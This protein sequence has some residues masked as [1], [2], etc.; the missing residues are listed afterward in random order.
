MGLNVLPITPEFI[1]IVILDVYM[2]YLE[3]ETSF[4][5]DE[6][7]AVRYYI[8]L[9]VEKVSVTEF[10]NEAAL[11]VLASKLIFL[12][13]IENEENALVALKVIKDICTNIS[14]VTEVVMQFLSFA[15]DLLNNFQTSLNCYFDT[16]HAHLSVSKIECSTLSFKVIREMSFQLTSMIRSLPMPNQESIAT[17]LIPLFIKTVRIRHAV[18]SDLVKFEDFLITQ[19]NLFKTI[20]VLIKSHTSSEEHK[21]SLFSALVSWIYFLPPNND[22]LRKEALVVSRQFI[23]HFRLGFKHYLTHFL[24]EGFLLGTKGHA[25]VSLGLKN[26]VLDLLGDIV[27]N[28]LLDLTFDQIYPIVH[29]L[30]V[31]IHD[32]SIK[33][34]SQVNCI[35]LLVHIV[36]F[37]AGHPQKE[38][39]NP[40]Y[41]AKIIEAFSEKKEHLHMLYEDILLKYQ[42]YQD[43]EVSF[44]DLHDERSSPHELVRETSMLT[45]MLS[46]GLSHIVYTTYVRLKATKLGES[47]YSIHHSPIFYHR[48]FQTWLQCLNLNSKILKLYDYSGDKEFEAR[49]S[50]LLELFVNTFSSLDIST[51]YQ[52]MATNVKEVYRLILENE[53]TFIKLPQLLLKTEHARIFADLWF[54]FLWNTLNDFRNFNDEE[55]R[56]ISLL[57]QYLFVD[58]NMSAETYIIFLKDNI[59]SFLQDI[60]SSNNDSNLSTCFKILLNL[61]RILPN[62]NI[63]CEELGIMLPYLCDRIDQ[64]LKSDLEDKRYG[65]IDFMINLP[66]SITTLEPYFDKFIDM[67]I[68]AME[69]LHP[70]YIS[71][72]LCGFQ[73]LEQW[74]NYISR[75]I[76]HLINDDLKARMMKCL[77][78]NIEDPPNKYTPYSIRIL[79]KISGSIWKSCDNIKLDL[80]KKIDH[81]YQVPVMIS[82]SKFISIPLKHCFESAWGILSQHKNYPVSTIRKIFNLIK[83]FAIMAL[84]Y[85]SNNYPLMIHQSNPQMALDTTSIEEF[86]GNQMV[87]PEE[88]YSDRQCTEILFKCLIYSQTID[89]VKEEATYLVNWAN[90]YFSLI[91]VACTDNSDSALKDVNLY[92]DAIGVILL[93]YENLGIDCLNSILTYLNIH[94]NLSSYFWLEHFV[95]KLRD[96]CFSNDKRQRY[97]GCHGF[98]YLATVLPR[99]LILKYQT[100]FYHGISN[101]IACTDNSNFTIIQ[102]GMQC[103][104]DIAVKIGKGESQLLFDMLSQSLYSHHSV[105]RMA[106]KTCI[107]II[108]KHFQCTVAVLLP[109]FQKSL[110]DIS[111][112]KIPEPIRIGHFYALSY[113]LINQANIN[114]GSESLLNIIKQ[115]TNCLNGRLSPSLDLYNASLDLLC[116]FI[117]KFKHTEES[118]YIYKD[119]LILFLKAWSHS[120]RTL[121]SH[122]LEGIKYLATIVPL[123]ETI[124]VSVKSAVISSYSRAII[125]QL[126]VDYFRNVIKLLVV[127]NREFDIDCNDF[128]VSLI[129]AFVCKDS[130][131]SPNRIVLRLTDAII[132]SLILDTFHL[133]PGSDAYFSTIVK[134]VI[135][136]EQTFPCSGKKVGKTLSLYSPYRA[137]LIKYLNQYS[138]LAVVHFLPQLSKDTHFHLFLDA[139]QNESSTR[140]RGELVNQINLFNQYFLNL[141]SGNDERHALSQSETLLIVEALINYNIDLL[142]HKKDLLDY[143][144]RLWK[145]FRESPYHL[146]FMTERFFINNGKVISRILLQHYTHYPHQTIILFELVSI[147]DSTAT[148]LNFQSI[149]SYC[150]NELLQTIGYPYRAD[151]LKDYIELSEKNFFTHVY[152]TQI[153]RILIR[154]IIAHTLENNDF[155]TVSKEILNTLLL[156]WSELLH[157][158]INST[159][160]TEDL[161]LVEIIKIAIIFFNTGYD[162]NGDHIA[163]WNSLAKFGLNHKNSYIREYSCVFLCYFNIITEEMD[164]RHIL[165][166]LIVNR[167]VEHSIAAVAL[168]R[169]LYF[170][171]EKAPDG[172]GWIDWMKTITEDATTSYQHYHILNVVLRNK[173]ISS[174]FKTTLYHPVARSL[175]SL[176]D[177]A[178]EK[179]ILMMAIDLM[180]DWDSQIQMEN[181]LEINV[182]SQSLKNKVLL[183]VIKIVFSVT[184]QYTITSDKTPL[185][186]R[187]KAL[188][189]IRKVLTVWKDSLVS[190]DQIYNIMAHY[191]N[192]RDDAQSKM[193]D[194]LQILVETL[195]ESFLTQN[196][197]IIQDILLEMVKGGC[198]DDVSHK[199][200]TYM[201]TV[202]A[203]SS[204]VLEDFYQTV[205]TPQQQLL[206]VEDE[207]SFNSLFNI[208]K[209]ILDIS[210]QYLYQYTN[211]VIYITSNLISTD[212]FLQSNIQQSSLQNILIS[213]LME[214]EKYYIKLNLKQRAF[215]QDSLLLIIEK[216]EAMS[217]VLP[218][219]DI[220][221]KWVV[222][223]TLPTLVIEQVLNGLSRIN[224]PHDI[225][226]RQSYFSLIL[227]LVN[228]SERILND[229]IPLLRRAI[230]YGDPSTRDQCLGIFLKSLPHSCTERLVI[231]LSEDTWNSLHHTYWIP[232][233]VF[234]L[235]HCL[236]KDNS[237]NNYNMP[238]ST[239]HY[240]DPQTNE[241]FMQDISGESRKQS[242]YVHSLSDYGLNMFIAALAEIAFVDSFFASSLWVILLSTIWNE[243]LS[244]DQKVITSNQL[245]VLLRSKSILCQ[246]T[247]YPNIVQSLLHGL[248]HCIDSS[249]LFDPK[250]LEYLG[251]T[252]NAW[253]LSIALLENQ[254]DLQRNQFKENHSWTPVHQNLAK[255]YLSLNEYDAFYGLMDK[256]TSNEYHKLAIQFERVGL[257]EN[258]QNYYFK[259]L[260]RQNDAFESETEFSLMKSRWAECSRKLNQWDALYEYSIENDD[261]VLLVES[262]SK[263]GKWELLKPYMSSS[264]NELTSLHS[265]MYHIYENEWKKVKDSMNLSLKSIIRDWVSFPRV[266]SPAYRNLLNQ[267]QFLIET[268][269]FLNLKNDDAESEVIQTRSVKRLIKLWR[270][271]L[272]DISEEMDTWSELLLKRKFLFK[273]MGSTLLKPDIF[274]SLYTSEIMFN[275]TQLAYVSRKHGLI[276]HSL[277]LHTLLPT[278]LKIEKKVTFIKLTEQLKCFYDIGVGTKESIEIITMTNMDMFNDVQKAAIFRL[279]AQFYEL[280]GDFKEENKSLL[281]SIVLSF[282]SYKN[283]VQW[284]GFFNRLSQVLGNDYLP[285]AFTAYMQSMAL[286]IEARIHIPTILSILSLAG[287]LSEKEPGSTHF[288]KI[289]ASF[290]HLSHTIPSWV[291]LK[292]IRSLLLCLERAERDLIYPFLL[293]LV[294]KHPNHCFYSIYSYL[295]AKRDI[296]TMVDSL[297]DE[298]TKT[299]KYVEDIANNL[300]NAH[301]VFLDQVLQIGRL[302]SESLDLSSYEHL[303]LSFLDLVNRFTDSHIIDIKTEMIELSKAHATQFEKEIWLQ[304]FI[305]AVNGFGQTFTPQSFLSLVFPVLSKLMALIRNQNTFLPIEIC[306]FGIALDMFG[307]TYENKVLMR[308]ETVRICRF[309][310]KYDRFIH[311]GMSQRRIFL[312]GSDGKQ[313]SYYV[314]YNYEKVDQISG[315]STIAHSKYIKWMK[316]YHMDLILTQINNI[317]KKSIQARSKNLSLYVPLRVEFG[318]FSLT[319]ANDKGKSLYE[320]YRD[321]LINE[322]KIEI[323]DYASMLAL[324]EIPL[325]HMILSNA[326]E[327]YTNDSV[328]VKWYFRSA[329]GSYLG[330]HSLMQY[331]FSTQSDPWHFHVLLQTG[332]TLT[333][334]TTISFDEENFIQSPPVPFRLT[335]NLVYL[336]GRSFEGNF[337]SSLLA[338]S[339][340]LQKRRAKASLLSLIQ[341]LMHEYLLESTN[342]EDNKAKHQNDTGSKENQTSDSFYRTLN[343]LQM[344]RNI[345]LIKDRIDFV[346]HIQYKEESLPESRSTN[347]KVLIDMA[348]DKQNLSSM[349]S[350]WCSS[351]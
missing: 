184:S 203:L 88:V 106:V 26:V 155:S 282:D 134:Y 314:D 137:P 109:A 264:E 49:N 221:R 53:K 110:V 52:I 285:H 256:A 308:E 289:I 174:S 141:H 118:M 70:D 301:P 271:R 160:I 191:M 325:S 224:C 317:F 291:W 249:S 76:F 71:L 313:Y 225:S 68:I 116:T 162:R 61:W 154:P 111:L 80:F 254:I 172:T 350:S 190:L 158:N 272:P 202:S 169:L 220:I 125:K 63:L 65:F 194:V 205:L 336:L 112:H 242:E 163:Y 45:K 286:S 127:L 281:N 73:K 86:F 253:F 332:K 270:D 93:D 309:G 157:N 276:N 173:K 199:I 145:S 33:I 227:L 5:R 133:L 130:H 144:L 38:H 140:L 131:S 83:T 153:L 62:I 260:S 207:S 195:N 186:L 2:S 219:L 232:V 128:M 168:D 42:L 69:C 273:H 59:G 328:Q 226:V 147:L 7:Q 257:W 223:N 234:A 192:N 290:K 263:L 211:L 105:L 215:F 320:L 335:P 340:A 107:N 36:D 75:N 348:T 209:A 124:E 132:P 302:L 277:R 47:M 338:A 123:K 193:M 43:S 21:D 255:L 347:I 24:N 113:Y 237:L 275:F 81:D 217:I 66:L 98:F 183:T 331:I 312:F 20:G 261:H 149:K 48:L 346:S 297:H 150:E 330:C 151:I 280:L 58:S 170:F 74:I 89:I 189:L 318:S 4:K 204:T 341:Y 177:Y 233:A 322:G 315:K 327:P 288:E 10:L 119:C 266:I 251:K 41:L 306:K 40:L 176:L 51:F 179:K 121:I 206:I 94:G 18:I 182:I 294:L 268:Q 115:V 333:S 165:R 14:Y 148:S 16:S 267:I 316:E 241:V 245:N 343:S 185:F 37:L 300:K 337:E 95:L 178:P 142:N 30:C 284:G 210:H 159:D 305:V 28:T 27:K 208:Y 235:L 126:E 114:M 197:T 23:C 60:L 258:A 200:V 287:S 293:N 19:T 231:I 34:S 55:I 196:K 319:S 218:L 246:K 25:R 307:H 13:S 248:Y 213:S 238:K 201:K 97:G 161:L 292:W 351:L 187:K 39:F 310:L 57:F 78:C 295:E 283:W 91:C 138:R 99:D 279:K 229:T 230:I 15:Q 265:T 216:S 90:R 50:E 87:R 240:I 252:Y 103:F 296:L 72:K 198:S 236:K 135:R 311:L 180:L 46:M 8:L 82:D 334:K 22:Q 167:Q 139:V 212:A 171:S 259:A 324:D 31:K 298:A 250:L 342:Y 29:L 117:K 100:C 122:A 96:F 344:E 84:Q 345:Q 120:D 228:K 164:Q 146:A 244:I 77:W 54:Q 129:E 339:C 1:E 166:N 79:G 278:N 108:A 214:L 188:S 17:T 12:A 104:S 35:S 64:Y 175:K 44:F 329:L 299:L 321:W 56:R 92:L 239:E 326:I 143:I 243:C 11:K 269:E 262:L 222:S 247:R 323:N 274:S 3:G 6:R 181:Y 101:I 156:H 303:Y 349:P 152:H 102:R 85:N 304:D 67:I 136:L 9:T 32:S